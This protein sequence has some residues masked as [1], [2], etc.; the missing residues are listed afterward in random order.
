M[1]TSRQPSSRLCGEQATNAGL[2]P[3]QHQALLQI[4]DADNPLPVHKVPERLDIPAALASR[5]I[6]GLE[7][8]GLVERDR[9]ATDRRISAVK[10]SAGID[11]LCRIDD[12]VHG[13]MRQFQ[14]E[15]TEEGKIGAL[16]TLSCYLGLDSGR[17]SA[18]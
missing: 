15:L 5:L 12:A 4:C 11:L 9:H 16:A 3:L 17:T 6:R 18:H 13:T 14:S 1:W 2:T 10:A 7:E 8:M